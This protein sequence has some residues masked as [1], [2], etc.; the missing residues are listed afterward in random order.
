M[1]SDKERRFERLKNIM[2]FKL[3]TSTFNDDT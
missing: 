3:N 1:K 2:Q